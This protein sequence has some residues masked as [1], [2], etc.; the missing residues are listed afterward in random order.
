MASDSITE[1][2]ACVGVDRITP[3]PGLSCS[4]AGCLLQPVAGVAGVAGVGGG[5]VAGAGPL[6]SAELCAAFARGDRGCRIADGSTVVVDTETELCP[7][8]RAKVVAV[9]LHH[10]GTLRY[11]VRLGIRAEED[12]ILA[13]CARAAADAAATEAAG[14]TAWWGE[15]D[16][17]ARPAWIAARPSS[18]AGAGDGLFLRRDELREAAG[19]RRFLAFP[20]GGAIKSVREA[21]RASNVYMVNIGD[22]TG[23]VEAVADGAAPHRTLG[24]YINHDAQ[25]GAFL[26]SHRQRVYIVLDTAALLGEAPAAFEV[27]CS[28]NEDPSVAAEL[29]APEP[30]FDEF[31]AGRCVYYLPPAGRPLHAEVKSSGVDRCVLSLGMGAGGKEAEL[32]VARAQLLPRYTGVRLVRTSAGWKFTAEYRGGAVRRTRG[33][34]GPEAALDAAEQYNKWVCEFGGCVSRLNEIPR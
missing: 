2:M 33:F 30:K 20:Y 13:A 6:A 17:P 34:T 26:A 9:V 22:G 10:S 24:S 16:S 4:V 15:R 8:R 1:D 18:I 14:G 25:G 11:L 12:T 7:F 32:E 27:F 23:G 5:M 3:V 31:A 29:L 19:E 28:Y 21:E